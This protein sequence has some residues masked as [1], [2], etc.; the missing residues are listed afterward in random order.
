VETRDLKRVVQKATK[1][2][3]GAAAT[4]FDLYYPRVYRYALVKLRHQA[5]AE[6]VAAETFAKVLRE[7]KRFKWQGGG[8]EAWLF[9]IASNVV[10]DQQRRSSR[11]RVVDAGVEPARG[12]DDETP[13]QIAVDRERAKR[14]GA[15][16][17]QL[18]DDQRDVI[19]PRFGA[20]LTSQETARVMDRKPNAIRQLQ[21]RALATLRD[22]TDE[23][24]RLS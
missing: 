12:P 22:R 8:F 6:D 23:S 5:D 19:A 4:L 3:E 14:L 11:E 16:V 15:M 20:G 13:E 10:V 1:G 17:E 21:F 7:L 2:D 24:E 9:R 18:S